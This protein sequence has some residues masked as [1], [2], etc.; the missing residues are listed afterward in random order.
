MVRQLKGGNRKETKSEKKVR[1]SANAAAKEQVKS[2]V[3]PVLGVLT[4]LV[5]AYIFWAT[6]K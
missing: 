2:V 3:F 5:A 6:R 4:L 1:R